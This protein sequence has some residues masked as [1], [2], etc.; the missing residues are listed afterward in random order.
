MDERRVRRGVIHLLLFA[1]AILSLRAS[2]HADAVV[3][4]FGLSPFPWTNRIGTIGLWLALLL[5]VFLLGRLAA[6]VWR[7]GR[8]WR[9]C[10]TDA[11]LAHGES[12]TAM[13]EFCLV[14]P[15]MAFLMGLVFQMALIAN[16]SIVVRY[17]A[18]AGA[19][20][21]IVRLE[22]MMP[23]I[24]SISNSD[25][26]EVAKVAKMITATLS[27]ASTQASNDLAVT[28]LLTIMKQQKGKWGDKSY[29]KRYVYAD[30]ATKVTTKVTDS[31]MLTLWQVPIGNPTEA[32]RV[33]LVPR[34][35]EV[36]VEYDFFINMPGV[37]WLTGVTKKSPNVSGVNGY[38]YTIK[39]IAELQ[40]TGSRGNMLSLF[41]VP[42]GTIFDY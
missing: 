26:N 9:A 27:P 10:S 3:A 35:A 29:T 21:A 14:F 40:G 18:W 28:N 11:S 33:P 25:K 6:G 34:Q 38:V 15:L 41:A 23:M 12:G 20:A 5:T 7:R 31:P 16:A 37:V 17:A 42:G 22:G 24:E 2:M 4:R 13:V 36:T 30:K 19:R 8:D 32:A 39:K 1:G